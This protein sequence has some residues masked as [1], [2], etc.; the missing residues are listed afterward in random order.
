MVSA[1]IPRVSRWIE[2][3][4]G[5]GEIQ[6]VKATVQPARQQTRNLRGQLSYKTAR[7][8]EK[9]R[10]FDHTLRRKEVATT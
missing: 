8:A 7:T 6:R 10:C 4:A 1:R 2:V 9:Q 5:R 3:H